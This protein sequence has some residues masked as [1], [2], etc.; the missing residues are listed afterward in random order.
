MLGYEQGL[1]VIDTDTDGFAVFTG[2]D[3]DSPHFL[4]FFVRREDAETLI[5]LRDP[6]DDSCP[7]YCDADIVIA[8]LTEHGVVAANDIDLKTH[9]DLRRR[10]AE[11]T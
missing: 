5:A 9:A 6:S 11:S 10:I 2:C 1:E 8:V 4:G 7:L 3:G